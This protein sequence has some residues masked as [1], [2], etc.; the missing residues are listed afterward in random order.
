MKME[1]WDGRGDG[2]AEP[3]GVS[4]GEGRLLKQREVAE[5]KG[6]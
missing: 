4:C 6:K 1:G 2:S 5:A 3:R